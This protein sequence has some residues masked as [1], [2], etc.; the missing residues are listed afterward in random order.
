MRHAEAG[1]HP[2]SK[3]MK[4]LDM[5]GKFLPVPHISGKHGVTQACGLLPSA[6]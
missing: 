5:L 1:W 4:I 6:S 3:A 2:F